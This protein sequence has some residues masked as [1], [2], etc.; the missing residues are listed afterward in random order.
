MPASRT[1]YT[2]RNVPKQLDAALRRR[3][4]IERKALN[5]VVLEAMAE[6]LGLD[7]APV[8]HRSFAD[9]LGKAPKDEALDEALA[10]QRRIDPD[11]WR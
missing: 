7:R 11:L 6:G 5:Q 9:V 10:D 2:I 1:Q 3:A 4:R 8:V